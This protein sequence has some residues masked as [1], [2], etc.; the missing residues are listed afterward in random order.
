[1]PTPTFHLRRRLL[2]SAASALAG[3][4]GAA[5]G[6]GAQGSF[7]PTQ[8]VVDPLDIT[9]QSFSGLRLPL[10]AA[11]GVIDLA[12][13]RAWVWNEQDGAGVTQRL[14]LEGDVVATL[15]GSTFQARRAAVWLERVTPPGGEASGDAR[16]YQVFVYFDGVGSFGSDAATALSARRLSVDGV[17]MTGTPVRLAADLAKQGRPADAFLREAEREMARYLRELATGRPIAIE[18][19]PLREAAPEEGAGTPGRYPPPPA[20]EALVEAPVV[21]DAGEEIFADEGVITFDAGDI[22]LVSG[23]SGRSL[24]LTGGVEVLYHE[25]GSDRRLQ[26]RAQRAV[27][28]LSPGAVSELGQLRAE[29]VE[30]LYLEG[31]VIATDGEYTLRGPRIYYDVARDRAMIVDAVFWTYDE[32]LGMPLY[33]RADALRQES[34]R[35]FVAERAQVTNT[36]FARPHLSIGTSSITV[37]RYTRGDGSLGNMVDAGDVTLLGGSVPFF[38]WPRWVGDPQRFPLRDARVESS[39]RTGP[40]WKTTWDVHT[41]LGLERPE[42]FDSALMLDYYNERGFATGTVTAWESE[43][44]RGN[45][46]AYLL[47]DDHGT[48]IMPNGREIDVD[49]ETRGLVLAEHRWRLNPLWNL[50]LEGAYLSDERLAQALFRDIAQDRRE[51]TTRARLDRTD[52][53]SQF[54]LEAKGT[55]NDFISNE[56]LLSSR[57]YSVSKLPEATYTRLGD[58]IAG[59][60]WPGVLS[61]YSEYRVGRLNME[62][63]EPTPAELGYTGPFISNLAFGVDPDVSIADALR[64]RGLTESDVLRGDTRQ[65]LSAVLDAGPLRI[66]PFVVG[67]VTAYDTD[68]EDYSPA[69]DDSVRLWGAAGVRLSTSLQRVDN[70]VESDLLDLHRVRHIIE[71]GVTIWHGGTTIDRADLPVYDDSVES[72]VEGTMVRVGI[73]QT[74]QTKRGGP[75]RWR[76]VDVLQLRTEY[77]WSSDDTDGEYAIERWFEFR[78]ELSSPGEFVNVEA[79][80]Q[81]SDPVGIAGRIIYDVDDTRQPEYS[82]L[83]VIV[84]HDDSLRSSFGQRFVNALDSTILYYNLNYELTEKYRAGFEVTYNS[85]VDTFD[86]VS[87]AVRRDYPS[88]TLGLAYSYNFIGEE[89]SIGFILS[90]R[91]LTGGFGVRSGGRDEQGSRLGG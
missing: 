40:V 22:T 77:I 67:R 44:M 57:G 42:G 58:S 39:S 41:L 1:M 91:G 37:K 31:D 65:E 55:L 78:P 34:S 71:P 85:D 17:V 79:L 29:D 11:P 49:G 12:A 48:D 46:F 2:C 86:R 6:Q 35:E 68:F 83:G 87:V 5:L 16:T 14:L 88:I 54:A 66:N 7:R 23:E 74:W 69:E 75:G 72:L 26:M 13:A 4:A 9:G 36:R 60:L 8:P 82:T 38:Y 81:V 21:A 84:D 32:R 50:T 63:H 64:A 45:V 59:E 80:W 24:L 27:V 70:T 62:F 89:S 25:V 61:L 53:S 43:Q 73:D 52:D 15:G 20:P 3:L 90:P 10:A 51:L 28:F 56:Y 33:V 47:F 76:D 30:G 19:V 18:D